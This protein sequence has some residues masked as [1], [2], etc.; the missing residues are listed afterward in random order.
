[1]GFNNCFYLCW[2]ILRL[3]NSGMYI[4]CLMPNERWLNKIYAFFLFPILVCKLFGLLQSVWKMTR[5]WLLQNLCLFSWICAVYRFPTS[6][7]IFKSLQPLI[8]IFPVSPFWVPFSYVLTGDEGNYS[9]S[10]WGWGFF[11]LQWSFIGR[12]WGFSASSPG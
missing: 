8:F 6:T 11:G 7:L 10:W 1:M 9:W 12:D 4:L 2:S 3:A 5:T